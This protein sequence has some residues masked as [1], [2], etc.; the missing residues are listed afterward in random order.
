MKNNSRKELGFEKKNILEILQNTRINFDYEKPTRENLDCLKKNYRIVR[1]EKSERILVENS[2]NKIGY[3]GTHAEMFA[4]LALL[5][6]LKAILKTLGE[7]YS[8]ILFD[9]FRS[10]ET[11]LSIYDNFYNLLKIKNFDLDDNQIH[12]ETKKFVAHPSDKKRFPIPPH[13]S[14]GAID[15]SLIY[16]GVVLDMGTKFDDFSELAKT[17][18]FE[19]EYDSRIGLSEI[20]WK[21]IRGNRRVLFNSMKMFG[22]TNYEFEWWHFDIGNCLWSEKVGIPWV[23]DSAEKEVKKLC[24]EYTALKP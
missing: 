4:R 12:T 1:V 23:F 15:L 7:E 6:K 21:N 2:Y 24:E 16:N 10:N 5:N 8:F 22:F 14:G 9:S 18:F 20:E 13:N 19:N 11:Q 17:D 3:A